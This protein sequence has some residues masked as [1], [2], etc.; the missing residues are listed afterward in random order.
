M[1]KQA[2]WIAITLAGTGLMGSGWDGTARAQALG[3]ISTLSAGPAYTSKDGLNGPQFPRIDVVMHLTG[4][5]GAPRRFQA[6]DLKL[7]E[8][9]TELGSGESVRSFAEAGYGVKTILALDASGSMNGAPLAAIHS[10]IAKFVNQARPQDQ[11][12]VLTIADDTR[13]EVPFGTDQAVL[14]S[15]LK[16]VAC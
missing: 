2:L 12:E 1:I 15:R 13:V 3:G 4:G 10:S 7:F 16:Q 6:G 14:A 9:D 11:V 8:G 5:Q